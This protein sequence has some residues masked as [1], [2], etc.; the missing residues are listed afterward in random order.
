MAN[1]LG[2]FLVG[3]CLAYLGH[4]LLASLGVPLNGIELAIA[5]VFALAGVMFC[6][7]VEAFER[8]RFK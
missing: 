1:A 3:L 6:L 7:A 4:K 2:L 8:G 5:L